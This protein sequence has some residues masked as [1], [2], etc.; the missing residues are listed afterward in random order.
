MTKGDNKENE[1]SKEEQ[2]QLNRITIDKSPI[3]R[4]S[5]N[6]SIFQ[7]SSNDLTQ[8]LRTESAVSQVF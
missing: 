2:T 1:L 6:S 4:P 5:N 8:H 3:V 7:G